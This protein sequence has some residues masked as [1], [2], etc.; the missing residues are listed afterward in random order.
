MK[1]HTVA[2]LTIVNI[3]AMAIVGC[4]ADAPPATA[5]S[6]PTEQPPLPTEAPRATEMPAPT[7]TPTAALPADTPTATPPPTATPTP[8]VESPPAEAAAGQTWLRPGDEMVM[9]YYPGGP[10]DIG[11]SEEDLAGA[12]Q[13]CELDRGQGRCDREWFHDEYPRHA[14]NVDAFWLDSTEVTN[15]QYA[16]FL[17]HA[18]NQIEGGVRWLDIEDESSLIEQIDESFRP[19]AGYEQHPVIEVSWYGAL[20]YCQWAGGW[21]P[22]EESWEYAARGPERREFPW[23]DE[24]PSCQ[25]ANVLDCHESVQP[26]GALPDGATPHGAQDMA[27]N[28]FEWVTDWSHPFPGSPYENPDFGTTFKIVR[29]GSWSFEPYYTRSAHRAYALMP[30]IRDDFVG[31]RCVI[32]ARP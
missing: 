22:S 14:I 21:L 19:K 30:D 32:P 6:L 2:Q 18:G 17:N 23:G 8:V 31:F 15:G 5:T 12:V 28:V 9:I 13:L 3:L 27:G 24:M 20:A 4:A 7:A 1:K 11:S 10:F 26:V 16:A 25:R 29:G